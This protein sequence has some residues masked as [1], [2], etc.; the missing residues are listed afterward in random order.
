MA[1]R[2]AVGGTTRA[3]CTQVHDALSYIYLFLFRF[4]SSGSGASSSWQL[5]EFGSCTKR[6]SRHLYR[7]IQV[8]WKLPDTLPILRDESRSQIYFVAMYFNFRL[9]QLNCI[10]PVQTLVEFQQRDLDDDQFLRIFCPERKNIVN[11]I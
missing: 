4:V 10:T 6:S 9:P 5:P 1:G 8:S 7:P 2:E 3:L 11:V